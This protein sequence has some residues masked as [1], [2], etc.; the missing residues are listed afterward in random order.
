[1]AA[2]R[3]KRFMALLFARADAVFNWSFGQS[4]NPLVCLGALG[5]F[6]FWIVAASGIYLYLF[7]DTG[8]TDAYASDRHQPPSISNSPIESWAAA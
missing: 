8:V 7:F 5:W 3:L 6:F 2:F 4:L 1:M